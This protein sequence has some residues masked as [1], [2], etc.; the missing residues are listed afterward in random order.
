MT[1]KLRIHSLMAIVSIAWIGTASAVAATDALQTA[2]DRIAPSFPAAR[3]PSAAGVQ[4]RLIEPHD[5]ADPQVL[6]GRL[7]RDDRWPPAVARSDIGTTS[8]GKGH[9][10][11]Q[12]RAQ[13]MILG[14]DH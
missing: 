14:N 9:F 7:L 1:T 4:G 13:S 11:P 6:A 3:A 8:T 2:R 10:D 5:Y 12:R